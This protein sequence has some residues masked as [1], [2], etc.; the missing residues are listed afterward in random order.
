MGE[1]VA[2]PDFGTLDGVWIIAEIGVNHD[3]HLPTAIELID[4]AAAAGAD[5]VKLQVF[6]P[7][8][9]A[10]STAELAP[11]Q[12]GGTTADSQR[13]MLDRLTLRREELAA[14]RQRA[15]EHGLAW[16]A[17]AF[18]P[19]SLT[20][21][22]ELEPVLHKIPSGEVTN[23][24][25]LR[26]VAQLGRGVLLSTGMATWEEVEAARNALASAPSTVLLHCLSAY[27]APAEQAN[28]LAIPNLAR[29]F[30][31]PVGWSDHCP[32]TETAVVAVG[33]GAVVLER[34]LTLDHHRPGPDHAASSTPEEL[35]DYIRA[36]RVAHAA[37]GT[38]EKQTQPAELPNR[39][40]ARR[41]WYTTRDVPAG[42]VLVRDDVIALRPETG[43]RP[44]VDLLG[45]TTRR[46]IAE[47]GSIDV[48]DVELAHIEAAKAPRRICVFTGSR[49][50]YGLLVPILRRIQQS[51][52][53]DLQLI[54]AGSHLSQLH[55]HTIDQ[56]REDGFTVDA[57]IEMLFA[58]DTPV[59]A[60][61]SVGVALLDLAVQLDRLRPDVL[62]VLGDRYELLALASAALLMNIPIAHVHGGELTEGAFDDAVRHAVTKMSHL[63][64][65]AAEEFARRIVQMGEPPE[66]VHVVGAPG[67]D[68]LRSLR[69]RSKEELEELLGHPLD[70]PVAL[71]AY[72]P[73]TIPGENPA[74]V[75]TNLLEAVRRNP[76]GT[77]VTSGPN[78]DPRYAGV[79]AAIEAA[80]AADGRVRLMPSIGHEAY[81][82]LMG[83]AAVVI[84]NSSSGIIEAPALGVPSVL[85]GKRQD[86]RPR[87]ARVIDT[88][89]TVDEITAAI[90]A[91]LAP[92]TDQDETSPYDRGVSA[93]DA[94]VAVLESTDPSRLVEK[95]FHHFGVR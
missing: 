61:K 55:G 40:A 78:A 12:V 39:R 59:A 32:G 15:D 26:A 86:G 20:L 85:V 44:D 80:A 64:F 89:T 63:H 29:R 3:G 72:H 13:E 16:F 17:T 53:L 11:Y 19:D 69:R 43:L 41:S 52:V 83:M 1:P 95:R 66:R 79:H 30:G 9:V 56:V 67:L 92:A 23:L 18:D 77:I 88:G 74:E 27:P 34:H 22:E 37:L 38:G 35:A 48:D 10:A 7:A 47:G 14:T 75:T 60:A 8:Q 91:A 82:S 62:V 33:L 57:E 65:P 58:S 25:Y 54:A 4:A 51:E 81:L 71:V 36:A 73:A 42:A 94:I 70:P 50:E 45:A 93:A 49:A 31:D 21:V 24:P 87:A 76:F 90:E 68:T 84:G 46:P 6:D 5:A 28:L 2:A